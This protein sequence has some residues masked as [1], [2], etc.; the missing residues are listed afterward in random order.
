MVGRDQGG[1]LGVLDRERIYLTADK[2][3]VN[4]VAAGGIGV[5]IREEMTGM[6]RLKY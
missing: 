1:K 6:M 2:G 3:P 5:T 4:Q